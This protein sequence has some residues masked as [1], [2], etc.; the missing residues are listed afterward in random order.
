MVIK[1]KNIYKNKEKNNNKKMGEN[2]YSEFKILSSTSKEELFHLQNGLEITSVEELKKEL[3]NMPEEVF[4][5]HVNKKKNDFS[6]WIRDVFKDKQLAEKIK[7]ARNKEEMTR[8]IE[9]RLIEIEKKL[10][11][12]FGVNVPN[13]K[14]ESAEK[15]IEHELEKNKS[16]EEIKEKL[17]KLGWKEKIID[18]IIEA[19]QNPYKEYEGINKITNMELFHKKT[20]LLKEKII[21]SIAEGKTIEE[22]KELLKRQRW[23]EEIIDFIFYDIYKPHP[24]LKKLQKYIIHQI[25]DKNKSI[26]EIKKTLKKLGWKEYIIN[27]VIYGL[28]EPE[29][30]LEKI[31]SYLH[32]FSPEE[33]KNVKY[34]LIRMGWKEEE[35]NEILRKK[36]LEEASKELKNLKKNIIKELKKNAEAIS[37]TTIKLK[38]NEKT[39]KI[40]KEI[41]NEGYKKISKE[42]F[43]EIGD[44]IHY[45]KDSEYYYSKKDLKKIE[46]KEKKK[47]EYY[48][49]QNE[50]KPLLISLKNKYLVIPQIIKRECM[51]TKKLLPVNKM[52]RIEMWDKTRTHKIIRYVS[53][54]YEGFIKNFLEDT[55]IQR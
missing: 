13:K 41:M 18:L 5:H 37:R 8:I 30:N 10:L 40:W 48:Y 44:E 53:K 7:K 43:K 15:Y 34:F 55:I 9:E 36:E 22:I 32:E 28:G 49:Y 50:K 11:K 17:K 20:E 23:H 12:K 46:E 33:E 42:E 45:H 35:I 24:N 51:V 21:N 29:N 47:I 31:L 38:D 3:K 1:A 27:S 25:R 16:I 39:K 2:E 26:E 6:K 4:K 14:L 19:K 54:E 52:K